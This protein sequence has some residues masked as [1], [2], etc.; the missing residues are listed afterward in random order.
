MTV[1]VDEFVVV[2]FGLK[3][4]VA[5]AGR[6]ETVRFTGELKPLRLVMETV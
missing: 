5:L 1:S 2:G 6:P 3:L 4:P